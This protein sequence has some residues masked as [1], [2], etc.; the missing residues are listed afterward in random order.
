MALVYCTI[1]YR[2]ILVSKDRDG[3]APL[4]LAV[5]ANEHE[6]VQVLLGSLGGAVGVYMCMHNIMYFWNV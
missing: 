5:K 3:Y 4:H 6:I 2:Y 1:L